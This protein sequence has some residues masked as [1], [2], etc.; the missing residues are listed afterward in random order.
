MLIANPNGFVPAV[1]SDEAKLQRM[2]EGG[3]NSL[4]PLCRAMVSR[5]LERKHGKIV[6]ASSTVG[7][8]GRAGGVT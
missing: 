8:K 5:I 3:C 2:I 4:H 7:L 1:E 6:A